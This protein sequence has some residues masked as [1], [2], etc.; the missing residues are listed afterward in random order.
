MGFVS[1]FLKGSYK[2]CRR[3]EGLG[4]RALDLKLLWIPEND[5]GFLVPQRVFKSFSV[6]PVQLLFLNF[7][8][9]SR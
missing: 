2:G 5:H 8:V 3:A 6:F 7:D 9:V 1:G 4:F